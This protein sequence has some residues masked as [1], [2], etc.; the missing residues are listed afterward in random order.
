[1]IE[2]VSKIGYRIAVP[3]TVEQ[4]AFRTTSATD[5]GTPLALPGAA[6]RG[7]RRLL[8]AA[9]V[10]TAAAALA[11]A[12]AGSSKEVAVTKPRAV[13]SNQETLNA[14]RRL[15]IAKIDSMI[16]AGWNPDAPID[17]DRNNALNRLLEMCEWA[18]DHDRAKMLIVARALIDGGITLDGYNKWGDTPY[19]IAKARRYCGPDHPV[20]RMIHNMCYAKGRAQGDRCLARYELNKR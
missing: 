17:V 20:T 14:L 6:G 5:S 12:M 8:A 13:Y 4:A 15:D 11:F 18:P 1:L 10:A 2:S 3:V 9:G 19:S 7:D 16:A